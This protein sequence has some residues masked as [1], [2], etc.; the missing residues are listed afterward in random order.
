MPTAKFSKGYRKKPGSSP[1][2]SKRRGKAKVKVRKPE[3][4]RQSGGTSGDLTVKGHQPKT[5][6]VTRKEAR[7]ERKA[8][9]AEDRA[10][11]ILR[12]LPD[13]P[14]NPGLEHTL[15]K[16]RG[17]FPST[18]LREQYPRAYKAS[19]RA[20]F[21]YLREHEGLKEDP[22]AEFA[23]DT[24]AT[25]GVGVG[26]KA[27]GKGIQKVVVPKVAGALEGS[28]AKEA[29]EEGAK[30][31]KRLIAKV[32]STPRKVRS[33]PRAAKKAVGTKEGRQVLAAKEGRRLQKAGSRA[34]RRPVRATAAANAAAAP[35]GV[36]TPVTERVGALGEGTGRA[37]YENPDGT[38]TT[39]GRAALGII[40]GPVALV[41]AAGTS[42]L[43]GDSAPLREEAR[44]Q[45]EGTA[46]MAG[47]LLSGDP[48]T[49]QETVETESG[50]A[51][52]PL[53]PYA[54][55]ARNLKV[56]KDSRGKVRARVKGK[57]KVLDSETGD[58]YIVQPVGKLIEGHR[59]RKAVSKDMAREKARGETAGNR[60]AKPVLKHLGRS[61]NRGGLI[62]RRHLRDHDAG[63]VLA[64]VVQY[65]LSRNPAKAERQLDEI[66]AS[67]GT[68]HPDEIPAETVTDLANIKWIREHPEIFE[69]AHFWNAVDAYK[70]Q[71]K[72]IE[73]SGRK[74]VLAVGDVYGLARPEER[75]EAGVKVK[76]RTIR[77]KFAKQPETIQ[78]K[79]AELS[80][81]RSDARRLAAEVNRK[82][83]PEDRERAAAIATEM[84]AR[85]KVLERELKDYRSG[86]KQAGKDYV[87]EAQATIR[88]RE[89]EQP[90]YVKD[91]K[92]R[93]G[94]EAQPNF[95]GGRSAIK[96]H[97]ATGTARARGV[98]AR[99]LDTLV[100][101]SI[102]EP[103]LRQAMHRASTAFVERWAVP[104]KGKR[105][106]TSSELDRAINRGELPEG[107]YAILHSQFF[108]QAILD[109]H[110][111]GDEFLDAVRGSANRSI[112]AEV[113]GRAND[114]GNKYVLVPKE[115][116]KEFVHQMEPP[117]GLNRVLGEMNRAFTRVMLGFSPSWAVA[118]VVA[119]G[120]PAA[121]AVGANPARWARVARYLAKEDRRL[122]DEDRTAIDAMVG[123]SPG[124]TP[125]PQIQFKVDTNR[126]ASRFFRQMERNPVGKALLSAGKGEA[127][128]YL[129]RWKGG[130]FR[131]AVAAAQADR[132]LN[133][134]VN[135]LSELMKHQRSI[136]EAIKGKPLGE[137]IAYL[138]KHPKEAARL[139]SYLDDVMGNWRALTR[140]EANVAPLIV[141]YPF[142]RFSLRWTFWAFPKRH[143]VKA[144]ILYFLSQQN[145]EELEKLVG[146][147]LSSPRDY[148]FPAYTASNG[149]DAVLPGGSRIA[150]G[151]S[152]A[153]EAVGRNDIGQLASGM[154]PAAALIANTVY[155]KNP[156]TGDE[157]D[158]TAGR[159][160]LAA[161]QL[162]SVAPPARFMGWNRI[163]EGEQSP[164]SKY[165]DEH[166]PSGDLRSFALPFIPQSGAKFGESQ[167]HSKDLRAAGESPV[168]G[169]P[170]E[171]YEA[172]INHDW[173]KAAK[174]RREVL[175]A[176]RAG[177]R[178]SAAE[179]GLYDSGEID[180]E[181]AEILAF[182]TGHYQI[183]ADVKRKKK[184]KARIGGIG[185]R[186][187]GGGS[188]G[189]PIGGEEEPIGGRPLR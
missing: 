187:L 28:A 90:A 44:K 131:K 168:T 185:G 66:E 51:F 122:S 104:V 85:A 10:L 70:A 75:L 147:P 36:D 162:L 80:E 38:L 62:R 152:F 96:Q 34:A 83:D 19:E 127:L 1:G 42:A 138:A 144:T 15:A 49:V 107:Q 98:L 180:D 126:N 2:R 161:N 4:P 72:T 24:L 27:L 172:A 165:F 160:L 35:A 26:V 170:A 84:Q 145:A 154:N 93:Q 103:R 108:K 111:G 109:P 134:F 65:G 8:D 101:Q 121:L 86:F 41:G 124:V 47:R 92:P 73:T 119:E 20:A 88:E 23:I 56:Y 100:D 12:T 95:P 45:V 179:A 99:D 63:D 82:S 55:R 58:P 169:L 175:K 60:A 6:T 52:A 140:H 184:V 102:L 46:D 143:P 181:A 16:T 110:K 129:D 159:A 156:Y 18:D 68:R 117:R 7:A 146:G 71:A 31:G 105:Y 97:M 151:L 43:H 29:T 132:Q 167:R 3:P 11:Q 174:I 91:V 150:P 125:H 163:G 120:I 164:A 77:A 148:A 189:G 178:V 173:N 87:R 186:P 128:G 153:S 182:M 74:K 133:G 13:P 79:Q 53:L 176:E 21:D 155:G 135:S 5:P 17:R 130:K 89:L 171:L 123:E 40:T 136:A 33:A 157:A 25:G 142:V 14:A 137:Q 183:P 64:T 188:I 116:L 112:S 30:A 158:T 61:K 81:I 39:T 37:L 22:I 76:G 106:L 50:L 115:A 9:R 54:T 48:D 139:E 59:Q 32:R 114:P 166:D 118:Q 78:R 94:F 69:D 149:D 141:F 113:R 67:I 177:D 57:G